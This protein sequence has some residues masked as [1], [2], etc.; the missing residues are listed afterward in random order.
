MNTSTTPAGRACRTGRTCPVRTPCAPGATRATGA[1]SG[2]RS[3]DVTVTQKPLASAMMVPTRQVTIPTG[4]GR[5]V[6]FAQGIATIHDTNDL[7]YLLAREDC[8][9]MFTEYAI[10]WLPDILDK[11]SQVNADVHWPEG[12]PK[13]AEAQVIDPSQAEEATLDEA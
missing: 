7:P 2:H 3:G 5:S 1:H 11:T 6:R 8:K 4:A 9:V 13:E 10:S 12:W